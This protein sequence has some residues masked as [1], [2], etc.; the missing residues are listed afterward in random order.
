M[1]LALL[2]KYRSKIHPAHFELRLRSS[3]LWPLLGP[4]LSRVAEAHWERFH[5]PPSPKSVKQQT[6]RLYARRFNIRTFIETGTFFGDTIA[7]LLDEFELLISIELD[8]VLHNKSQQRFA[9]ESKV[10][11]LLGDSGVL[12]GDVVPSLKGPALFWLDAHYSGSVT[13]RGE[14]ETPIQR[15]LSIVLGDKRFEHSVLVD[16]A[17]DFGSRGYPPIS[18]VEAMVTMQRPRWEMIVVNDVIHIGSPRQ[19]VY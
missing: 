19:I 11:I 6:L 8:P 1:N 18:V 2:Q 4:I 16:D 10:R 15:E 14:T 13:A 12:L 7:E 3:R 17:R 5:V 9:G